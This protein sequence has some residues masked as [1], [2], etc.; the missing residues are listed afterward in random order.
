MKMT[1]PEL[2]GTKEQVKLAEE[3][4]REF[5]ENVQRELENPKW[6]WDHPKAVGMKEYVIEQFHE[7]LKETDASKWI[8]YKEILRIFVLY[9][10]NDWID[11]STKEE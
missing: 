11:M 8:T 10:T 5:I 6:R 2:K 4:R 3:I 9:T 1:L 7:K